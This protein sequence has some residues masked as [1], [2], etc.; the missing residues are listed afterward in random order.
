MRAF[1]HVARCF[2]AAAALAAFTHSAL[3]QRQ[4][5]VFVENSHDG[6]VSIIDAGTLKVVGSMNVGLSPDEIVASPKG[7]VL[8]LARIVR[9]E[10]GRP[11]PG[12]ELV[13]IDP[14]TRAILYRVP[15]RGSPNHIA[16]T[17]DG[18]RI[19]VTIVTGN[20]V[21]VVDPARRAVIDSVLVGTGPHDIEVSRDG[22]RAYVGLI[23]GTEVVVFETATNKVIARVPFSE[24]VRPLTLTHDETRLFVQLSHTHAFQVVN[25][26]NWR[27]AETV[28]MPLPPGVQLP[29]PMPIDVNHGLRVTLDG[30]YLI[31]NGSLFDLTAIYSV[32]DVQL[33]ATIPVGHD[34]NWIT[35]T[36]DGKRAFVS[37]RQSNDV[38]VIDLASRKEVARIKV[39]DYPQRMASV[40]VVPRAP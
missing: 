18:L 7:D 21:A 14:S 17:P 3:A 23:R 12:G 22:Q 4:Q 33:V 25:T 5:L 34:P 35:L 6:T 11:A 9:P 38:S 24:N 31:A 36:P 8:Y 32:P 20:H 15:L 1:R 37:N 26:H 19:Y 10:N 28:A 2:A 30:K 16:L 39:G 27:T 40:W 29:K 13:A